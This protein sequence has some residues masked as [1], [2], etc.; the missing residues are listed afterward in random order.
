MEST[1]AVLLLVTSSVILSCVAINYAVTV[2]QYTPA[3]S[4]DLAKNMTES[5]TENNP[6]LSGNCTIKI[7]TPQTQ[8]T[9]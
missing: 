5:F 4:D 6:L 2:V 9:P 7:E 3:Y 1:V 8:T